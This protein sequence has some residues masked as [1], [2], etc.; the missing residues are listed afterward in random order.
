MKIFR[1]F[2][3]FLVLSVGEQSAFSKEIPLEKA[4]QIAGSFFDSN[5][6]TRSFQSVD[7]QMIWDGGSIQ[8]RGQ[9]VAPAFYV[10]DNATGPG[11]VIV[12]GDDCA[13]PILGY[14][15][16]N[17]FI[18]ENMPPN[19]KAWMEGLIKAVAIARDNPVN[20][21]AFSSTTVGNVVQK[22]ETAKWNQNAPYN[23]LCP[24][25][26]GLRAYTGCVATAL[27]IVMRYHEWPESGTGTIPAYVTS[28]KGIYIPEIE[29]GHEYEWDNMPLEYLQHGFT[30]EQARQVAR[31]MADCGAML[32]M[33]YTSESSAAVSEKIPEILHKYMDY[34]ASIG[35]YLR[36]YYTD[37][38]WHSMMQ[39]EIAD[40]G[41]VIYSGHNEYS[42]H[43]FVL[44]GY[45]DERYYSLNWGWGGRCDG[46]YTLDALK[47]S[48]Q[49]IGGGYD[50]Y[51]SL[52]TAI[53]NVKRDEGGVPEIRGI[54]H[55]YEGISGL[56]ADRTVFEPNVPF[57][58][59]TGLMTNES[60]VHFDDP[61]GFVIV[62]SDGQ[63]QEIVYS[64]AANLP[65]G[66]GYNFKDLEVVF[67]SE[68]DFGYKLIA[69]MYDE[70]NER[71]VKI[72]GDKTDG[73]VDAIPLYE[74]FSVGA[75]TSFEY[76][77]MTKV[78]TLKVKNG[79]SAT[80]FAADGME[81]EGIVE[82]V[83]YV[84]N[85]DTASLTSGRYKLVVYKGAESVELY[86]IIDSE[87]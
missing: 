17:E 67:T 9:A 82:S 30:D 72:I 56:V 16:D 27:S 59:S 83:P 34:D 42:G 74:E 5:S 66:Y 8:T 68:L 10:F 52:Q 3:I 25:D 76:N 44:D 75:S 18:V 1:I 33:D 38:E 4:R 24:Y 55:P 61:F 57:K 37:D 41:P 19:V 35:V 50:D 81:I 65:A 12:S 2:V 73:S 47:P 7:L 60:N 46:Y 32:Q 43:A 62:D 26:E 87:N 23:D 40:N 53:L 70:R 22:H 80:V 54:I 84:I 11:F 49:G 78:I 58:I 36:A 64:F 6:S 71:W 39:E 85:I 20:F 15:F 51:N 45:T 14:S 21:A 48:D 29:L 69:A 63:V 86:F 28:S 13:R 31:L 79:V 77:T